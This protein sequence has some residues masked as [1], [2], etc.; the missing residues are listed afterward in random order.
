MPEMLEER[1]P[2]TERVYE[3]LWRGW[4]AAWEMRRSGCLPRRELRR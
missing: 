2:E 1:Y 3:E 4:N